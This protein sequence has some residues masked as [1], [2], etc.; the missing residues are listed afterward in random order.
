M[1]LFCEKQTTYRNKI[2]GHTVDFLN[3]KPAGTNCNQ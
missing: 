2:C 1:I 3:A